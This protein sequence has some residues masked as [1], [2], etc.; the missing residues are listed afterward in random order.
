MQEHPSQSRSRPTPQCAVWALLLL[1]A[2]GA[3]DAPDDPTAANPGVPSGSPVTITAG[4]LGSAIGQ[5]LTGDPAT[6]AGNAEGNCVICRN[7]VIHA[8]VSAPNPSV[9]ILDSARYRFR[10]LP[11]PPRF[12]DVHVPQSEVIRLWGTARFQV[13]E[14]YASGTENIS[15]DSAFIVT[16]TFYFR[17][18]DAATPGS[19][20]HTFTCR[21]TP[22]PAAALFRSRSSASAPR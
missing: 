12:T 21:E 7:V 3:C 13:G 11:D 18:G 8:V 17:S 15:A 1:L 4:G 2:L 6:C 10:F 20:S 22:P 5:R 19:F 16:R 14:A 9:A